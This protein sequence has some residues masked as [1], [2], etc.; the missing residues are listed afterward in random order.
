MASL[1]EDSVSEFSYCQAT[2]A[3][4]ESSGFIEYL[5]GLLDDR[6]HFTSDI[7]FKATD[8]L[9]LA[10]SFCGTSTQVRL[11]PQI[12]AQPDDDFAI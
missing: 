5:V 10:H 8:D 4:K 1:S 11:R 9:D 3:S 2:D 12:V 7:A 6:V